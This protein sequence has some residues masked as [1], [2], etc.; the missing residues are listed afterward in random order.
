MRSWIPCPRDIVAEIELQDFCREKP[1]CDAAGFLY[2][3][4]LKLDGVK[5]T[6][7]KI[8]K[9]MGWTR[10]RSRSLI[11][12]VDIFW[13]DWHLN[14]C[15]PKYD[16]SP[17]NN[18]PESD[19]SVPVA[20]PDMEESSTKSQPKPDQ[21]SATHAGDNIIKDKTKETKTYTRPLGSGLRAD[22]MTIDVCKVWDCWYR[23]N[24]RAKKIR[25]DQVKII[26]A[27][28]RDVTADQ[29]CDVIRYCNEAPET[30]PHVSFWRQ[31]SFTDI[32]NL[33]NREKLHRNIH[34][35]EEWSNGEYDK[36]LEAI[37]AM[38]PKPAPALKST[39]RK[40]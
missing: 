9:R 26:R 30:A 6:E 23:Y 15:R 16:Q 38:P 5:L 13:S 19:H 40:F 27:A 34:H 39:R 20:T 1:A 24:P 10:H 37:S 21:D 28:L 29:C 11:Q 25:K 36:P 18:Q 4:K 2:V 3:W 31:S 33:L 32:S 22:W 17:T 14:M 12:R 7:R 8:A 35:S